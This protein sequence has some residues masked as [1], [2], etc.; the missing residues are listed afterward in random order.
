MVLLAF[1]AFLIINILRIFILSL[2]AI[3]GSSL[4][5]ITH[6]FLW[7]LVSTVFV[8]GIWFAEVKFF[9]I[10]EIPFYSDIKSLYKKSHL[11]K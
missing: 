8:V 11:R 7:Y 5:D 1:G 6:W 9:K 3:S 10:R 4:F 2:F